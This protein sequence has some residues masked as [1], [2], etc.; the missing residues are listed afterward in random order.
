MCIPGISPA[1]WDLNVCRIKWKDLNNIGNNQYLDQWQENYVIT[2]L[3]FSL[4][5]ST[6]GHVCVFGGQESTPLPSRAGQYLLLL[7]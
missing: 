2:S 7:L 1:D 3:I 6:S 4:S 5:L